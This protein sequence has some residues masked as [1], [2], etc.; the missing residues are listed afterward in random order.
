MF[1]AI[2]LTFVRDIS[3][4][5]VMPQIQEYQFCREKL[6]AAEVRMGRFVPFGQVTHSCE[7]VC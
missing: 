2:P 1:Q 3:Q 6:E 5:F 4:P 7:P